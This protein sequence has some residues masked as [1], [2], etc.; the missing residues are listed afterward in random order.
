MILS[1][2]MK[3]MKIFMHAKIIRFRAFDTILL[4]RL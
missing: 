3:F 2:S 4:Q 1:Y